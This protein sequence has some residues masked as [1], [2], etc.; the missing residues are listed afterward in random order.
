M[1]LRHAQSELI[2]HGI[3]ETQV[4]LILMLLTSVHHRGVYALFKIHDRDEIPFMKCSLRA[5]NDDLNVARLAEQFG[6]GGHKSSSGTRFPYLTTKEH[7]IQTAI[8]AL[9]A[10]L[11]D[12]LQQHGISL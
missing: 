3:D 12:Y 6:G 1:R 5:A 11:D 7:S 9:N 8:A 4:E 10:K 2:D